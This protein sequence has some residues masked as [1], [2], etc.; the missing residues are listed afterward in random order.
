MKTLIIAVA[1]FAPI[2]HAQDFTKTPKINERAAAGDSPDDPGPLATYLSPALTHK[3]IRAAMKKVA[4]WQVSTGEPRFNQLWTMAA[5]YDGLLAYSQ[6]TKD[7]GPHDAVLRMSE[8]FKWQLIEDRF[9]HADDEHLAFS[10][11]NLY[12]EHP[13]PERI[14]ATRA[15]ADRLVARPDEAKPVWWWC[16]ALYMAPPVL[17]R[18]SKITGDRKYITYMDH[19]WDVTAALLY[20][21]DEQLY[22]RDASYLKKTE[23]NGRKLMWS[24]GNGW[25]V[26]GLAMILNDLPANDP[27]RPKY[28]ALLRTMVTKIASLQGS[29]GLWRTG[30]LDEESYKNAEIS[31][32]AFFTY[33]MAYGINHGLLDRKTFAPKVEKAWGAMVG[34]IYADGRLGSIQPIGAAPDDFQLSSSYVYGVGGFLSAGSEIDRMIEAGGP[35]YKARPIEKPAK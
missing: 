30:L 20:D 13:A 24:R 6:Q 34:H 29:D 31:G 12:T 33:A 11:L 27:L 16:D 25:V 18:L 9:P 22:F 7:P 23:K 28:E 5:L 3:D 19:E 15:M 2:A 8:H 1:L 26:A 17:V 10:Y 14:A 35:H 32:S 4:D 21:K